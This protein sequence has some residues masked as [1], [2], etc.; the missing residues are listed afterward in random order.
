MPK[1]NDPIL[2]GCVALDLEVGRHD[3][4]IHAFGAVYA[5]DGPSL[6]HS[7]DGLSAALERLE[8]FVKGASFVLGH[9]LIAF[10]LPH[11]KAAKPDLRLLRLPA[12]DT[13]PASVPLAL[14]AQ[15]LSPSREALPGRRA[16]APAIERP[17]VGR[18]FWHWRCSATSA[19]RWRRRSLISLRRGTGS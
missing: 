10:D 11:L 14:P 2:S 18:P 9:N 13:P 12:V 4:V 8:E 16:Q 7:G 5:S 1:Q 6:T 3:S 17:G 19:K 15:P